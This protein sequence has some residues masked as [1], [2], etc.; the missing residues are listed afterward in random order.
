MA[1]ESEFENDIYT[2]DFTLFEKENN[3]YKKSKETIKQYYHTTKDIADILSDFI[4]IENSGVTL[5]LEEDKIFLV[6]KNML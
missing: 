1:I 5:Y 6:L 3:Y 4:L 2:S